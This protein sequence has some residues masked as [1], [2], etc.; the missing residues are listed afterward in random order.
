MVGELYL[1]SRATLFCLVLARPRPMAGPPYNREG[2]AGCLGGPIHL[3]NLVVFTVPCE[4]AGVRRGTG[5]VTPHACEVTRWAGTSGS[6]PERRA[7]SSDVPP[8]V[9]VDVA[10]I[11]R[12]VT[13]SWVP[14]GGVAQVRRRAPPPR[15]SRTSPTSP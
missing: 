15:P 1:S 8:L 4:P 13:P 7:L 9:R 10:L 2:A 3:N 14:P 11:T 5:D 12:A 6:V